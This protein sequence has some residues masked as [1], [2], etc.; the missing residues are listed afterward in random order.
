MMPPGMP[1]PPRPPMGPPGSQMGPPGMSP[2]P[3]QMDMG[4][5]DMTM[6]PAP[7]PMEGVDLWGNPT[8]DSPPVDVDAMFP[9][10]THEEFPL[11]MATGMVP[12]GPGMLPEQVRAAAQAALMQKAQQRLTSSQGFQASAADMA[13]RQF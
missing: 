5:G 4:M 1:F 10:E 2:P 7:M 8:L 9:E 11:D 13:K 12:A 6:M 3:G